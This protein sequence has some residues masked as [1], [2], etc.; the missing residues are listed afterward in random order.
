MW[1]SRRVMMEPGTEDPATLGTVSI[2]GTSPAVITDAVRELLGTTIGKDH[3]LGDLPVLGGED[4]SLYL[5]KTKGCY[6]K[7]GTRK[8]REDGVNYPHHHARFYMDEAGLK[9]GV[10]AWLTILTGIEQ[11]LKNKEISL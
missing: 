3:M 2:G 4:F 5:T 7:I 8:Y 10:L 1:L 9:T 6:F 11:Q